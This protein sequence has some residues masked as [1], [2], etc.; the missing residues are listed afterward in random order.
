MAEAHRRT[1]IKRLA[2]GAAWAAGAHALIGHRIPSTVAKWTNV[3]ELNEQR[4]VVGGSGQQLLAAIRNGADL[5]I[6]T[7]FRHNEHID[8]NSYNDELVQEVADFRVT[9][10]IDE[11]WVAGIINLRQPIE[12]PLGFGE[13]PSMSFFMYNQNGDQ[14]IARP[15]LDGRPTTGFKGEGPLQDH[16]EMSKYHQ[17]DAWDNGTNAPSSNFVYDF[18]TYKFLVCDDWTEV[19]A[20]DVLGNRVSGSVQE[21][22]D[23]FSNGK[24]VKVG[25]RGLCADVQQTELAPVQHEVFIHCGSCYYYTQSKWFCAASHPV[26]RVQPAIPL[27]YKSENW[28]F[29]WLMVRSDGHVA[30]WLLNPHTLQFTRSHAQHAIRWFVR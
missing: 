13:R 24:E 14:A 5:R 1:F 29:G 10:A 12:L 22:A 21:L 19:Y 6:Y 4:H 26:V 27:K 11:R 18:D 23:A 30:R 25:I 17:H 20:N 2:G 16:A 8:L 9:Y 3:L 28:D 7:E 15:Y